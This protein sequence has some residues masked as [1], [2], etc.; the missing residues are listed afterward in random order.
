MQY[1]VDCI[2]SEYSEP[3]TVE[4]ISAR[5]G[6]NRSYFSALFKRKRGVSPKQY[7]FEYRMKIAAKL[8]TEEK[9]PVSVVANSVGYS[10]IFNFSKMF[11]RFSGHS[12]TEYVKK[13]I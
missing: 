7:L 12:P 9:K 8:L 13:N 3:I 5:L 10:D 4:E 1:A 11:K 6:L 2:H